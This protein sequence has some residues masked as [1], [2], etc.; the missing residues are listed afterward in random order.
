MSKN[1]LPMKEY[2]LS[3]R[4]KDEL[5]SICE[6]VGELNTDKRSID[7]LRR[8]LSVY[9]YRKLIDTFKTLNHGK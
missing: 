1:G 9:P 7:K 3:Q 5:K 4:T 8:K 6:A 2:F